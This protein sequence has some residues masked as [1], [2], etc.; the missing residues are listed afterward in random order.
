M[1]NQS[2]K[3]SYDEITQ[4]RI[5][6]A[7]VVARLG[8]LTTAIEQGVLPKRLGLTLSEAIVLGLLQ[9][10]VKGFFSVFCH[11]FTGVG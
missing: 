2:A 1:I 3:P 8:S 10:G 6:R 11:G 4:G 5:Q 7:S 9:Q